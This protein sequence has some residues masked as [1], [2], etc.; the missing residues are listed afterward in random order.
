MILLII[1]QLLISTFVSFDSFWTSLILWGRDI[2]VGYEVW[3]KVIVGVG[4]VVFN[5]ISMII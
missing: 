1:Q 3:V 4:K 5:V 2:H